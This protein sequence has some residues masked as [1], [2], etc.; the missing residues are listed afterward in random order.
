MKNITYKRTKSS[1]FSPAG[2]HKAIRNRLDSMTDKTQNTT[3]KKDTLKK[4]N[5]ET[6]S[7]KIIGGLSFPQQLCFPL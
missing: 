1:A 6:V 2:D 4:H 5:I 3:N 7:K